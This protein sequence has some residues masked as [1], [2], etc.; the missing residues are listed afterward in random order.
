MGK[1]S[2]N[3]KSI[4]KTLRFDVGEYLGIARQL[5]K[6][7]IPFSDFAR[8]AILKKRI[9]VKCHKELKQEFNQLN[10][11]MNIIK[12]RVVAKDDI[13]FLTLQSMG[14]IEEKLNRILNGLDI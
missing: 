10:H 4:R 7:D 2:V 14:R 13:D 5:E 3:P 9:K 11:S 8:S 1:M 6:Y 12:R